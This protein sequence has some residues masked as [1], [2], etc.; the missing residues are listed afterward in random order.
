MTHGLLAD[1]PSAGP[2]QLI[3]D[4]TARRFVLCL[5]AAYF[6]LFGFLLIQQSR[7]LQHSDD[8]PLYTQAL[9][10]TLQGRPYAISWRDQGGP[11]QS[12]LGLHFEPSLILFLPVYALWPGPETLLLGQV[13]F[14]ALAALPIYFAALH[15]FREPM[16]GLCFA[17]AHLFNPF[18]QRAMFYGFHH[19]SFQF[20]ALT[21]AA[22][23]VVQQRFRWF[24]VASLLAALSREDSFLHL[25]A[26]GLLA[27]VHQRQ[28][29]IGIGAM[30]ASV[31]GLILMVSVVIPHFRGEPHQVFLQR[32][33]ALG[34]DMKDIAGTM[35]RRPGLVVDLL[36]STRNFASLL[37]ALAPLGFLPLFSVTAGLLIAPAVAEMF[38]TP[39]R[40]LKLLGLLYP[41]VV[42]PLFPF[43]AMIGLSRTARRFQPGASGKVGLAGG[44][45]VLGLSLS[46]MLF[47][48]PTGVVRGGYH[49][50]YL[51]RFPLSVGFTW[52]YFAQN[53]HERIGRRFIAEKVPP[54]VPLAT[55][56]RLAALVSNRLILEPIAEMKRAEW[57]FFDLYGQ[58]YFESRDAFNQFLE[59]ADFGV[60]AFE[61]GY[62]LLRKGADPGGNSRILEIASNRFEAED[63]ERETGADA[64]DSRC[65]NRVARHGRARRDPPGFLASGPSHPLAAG[66]YQAVYQLKR[67]GVR[68]AG[69]EVAVL[70]VFDADRGLVVA[71]RTLAPADLAE[72]KGYQGV[73]LGFRWEESGNRI[74]LRIFFRSTADLWVD[75]IDI[76]KSY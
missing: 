21:C 18:I 45:G 27:L 7:I 40:S 44:L 30:A 1:P 52:E 67:G 55:E 10:S 4:S 15:L 22:S 62:T 14:V 61:D 8:T 41:F 48:P 58:P 34:D 75:R 63:L 69:A 2:P 54:E 28:V 31:I 68:T 74:Q 33:P 70:E 29:R 72:S 12:F 20:L 60:I 3:Q 65:V 73:P 9:W 36:F 11:G 37:T 56:Y 25:F 17:A 71:T 26:L 57:I 64:A 24:F 19:E 23:F 50:Y 35:L 16:I 13:L 5:A 42:L 59:G 32:Y 38:L 76:K 46:S 53:D 51:N 43:A 66:S 49:A 6:I 39:I 47:Y